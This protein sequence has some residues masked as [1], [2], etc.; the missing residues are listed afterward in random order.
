M[1]APRAGRP[2]SAVER[3]YWW[4][5][6]LSPLNVISRVSV[7]GRLDPELVREALD[8]L[9]RRHPLLGLR[10]TTNADGTEPAWVPATRRIPLRHVTGADRQRWV[11]EVNEVELA[12]AVPWD[13]G[14]LIRVTLLDR[15]A[16]EHDLL[17]TVPH[18]IADGTTVLALARDCLELAAKIERGEPLP[19]PLR[20]LPPPEDV[21]PA[22]HRGSVG[23][24][25]RDDQQRRDGELFARL[26][27]SRFEPTTAVPM[28][29]RR[30]KMLHRELAG[31]ELAAVV[32]ACRREKT[33]VHGLLAAA[34]ARAAARDAGGPSHF[35][36]G[37]PI[38]FRAELTPEVADDEVGT[39]VATVPTV[40]G[41]DAP[42]WAAARAAGADLARRK[43]L[44][45][46]FCL[47]GF[48][49]ASGLKSMADALP[50]MRHM[51]ENGP[52]NL[53]LSN[54]GRYAMPDE[55]GRWQVGDSQFV[56]GLSVN[57]YVVGTVNTSHDRL[58]WNCG[59]IADAVP[60]DRAAALIDD[61]L[62]TVLS[63]AR[64]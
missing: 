41:C 16:D 10:I 48:V 51:E 43:E 36:I 22:P 7:R 21:L 45:E 8:A 34:L 3:W 62:H 53:C 42:L 27:P 13:T 23:E 26:R 12:E 39:Y 47:V 54:L 20:E 32:D 52:I 64:A 11:R 9:Q 61:C 19:P 17:I 49:A 38:D 5:D 2:L 55:I 24:Q 33:T 31:D 58:F 4:C 44:G 30:T 50:V 15:D 29:A 25:N 35:A 18:C 28:A 60:D 40:V 59:Y 37:S 6:Q 14:P 56:A 57:G 1:T 46:H 63:A